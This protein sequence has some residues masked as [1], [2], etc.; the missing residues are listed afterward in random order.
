M[1]FPYYAHTAKIGVMPLTLRLA[2]PA[3]YAAVEPMVIDAFAQVTWLRTV[4]E[5]FGPLNGLDWRARWR[6]RVKHAFDEETVLLGE[7]KG[8]IVAFASGTLDD[9]TRSTYINLVAVDSREQGKG[10]GREILRGFMAHMKER[11]AEHAH[12]ECLVHNTAGN[13]LYE[14]EGFKVVADHLRWWIKL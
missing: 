2:A 3:D 1:T 10:Y 8:R 5:M 13:R 11:G 14:S 9:A 7:D 12:L 4:D 6:M